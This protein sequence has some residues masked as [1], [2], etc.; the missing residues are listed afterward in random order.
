MK[1]HTEDD[2]LFNLHTLLTIIIM[3]NQIAHKPLRLLEDI[4]ERLDRHRTDAANG[5]IPPPNLR[6]IIL[7]K[8]QSIVTPE[9]LAEIISKLR[10]RMRRRCAEVLTEYPT[11]HVADM[12]GRGGILP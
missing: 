1:N 8:V 2:R 3:S 10:P 9:R 6:K 12:H 5:I 11:S 7:T 4:E